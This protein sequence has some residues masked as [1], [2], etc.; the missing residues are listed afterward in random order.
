MPVA[1]MPMPVRTRTLTRRAL[2]SPNSTRL[3]GLY[4]PARAM[5]MPDGGARIPESPPVL[6]P[7]GVVVLAAFLLGGCGGGGGGGGGTPVNSTPSISNLAFTP[8]SALHGDGNGSI[9]VTG[10][11]QFVDAGGDLSTLHLTNPQCQS[12]SQ[13]ISGAMFSNQGWEHGDGSNLV[14]WT[15]RARN[16]PLVYLQPGDGPETYADLNYRRL[17]EN[18]IRWVCSEEALA[19]ARTK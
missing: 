8:V 18:A 17:I 13:A 4:V 15:K 11:L 7:I 12:L 19:W 10:S 2:V 3:A 9:T 16:S 1:T 14:G 6:P 5:R